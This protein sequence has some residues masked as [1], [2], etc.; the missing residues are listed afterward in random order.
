M[1]KPS[2]LIFRLNQYNSVQSSTQ[3]QEIIGGVETFML[4][5]FNTNKLANWSR[6]SFQIGE[7]M[8]NLNGTD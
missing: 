1:I 3:F 6:R 2:S 8:S 4:W 5:E 7:M